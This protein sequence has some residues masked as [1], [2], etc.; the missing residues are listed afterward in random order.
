MP[1]AALAVHELRFRLAYGAGAPHVLAAQG[2]GYLASLAPWI[3][4]VAA[5]SV[6]VSLGRLATRWAGGGTAH[7]PT[8]HPALR[9]WLLATFVLV[10]IYTGQELLEGAFASGHAAGP[11]GVFGGG[12]VWALPAALAVG[13]VLALALRV[14]QAAQTLGAPVL[15]RVRPCVARLRVLASAPAPFVPAAAPLASA[16]AGRAPP[17]ATRRRAVVA[18]EPAPLSLA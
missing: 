2:H 11:A 15:A 16:A 6:G 9:V 4:L 10:A 5:L 1:A 12:G 17:A 3:V 13:G 18:A 8:R 7:A 14:E